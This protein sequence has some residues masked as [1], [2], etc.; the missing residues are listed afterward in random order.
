MGAHH[1]V[2]CPTLSMAF[3]ACIFGE[4]DTKLLTRSMHCVAGELIFRAKFV[5]L[6]LI[7]AVC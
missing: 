7:L 3:E 4:I 5:F 6:G 1:K 2:V